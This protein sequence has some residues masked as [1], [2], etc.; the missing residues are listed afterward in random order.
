MLKLHEQGI[1]QMHAFAARALSVPPKRPSVQH[2]IMNWNQSKRTK[3]TIAQCPEWLKEA[4]VFVF[5]M[6]IQLSAVDLIDCD[7]VDKKKAAL[8]PGE[9]YRPWR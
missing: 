3:K 5:R 6:D 1:T 8:A 4:N 9:R 2:K 7:L